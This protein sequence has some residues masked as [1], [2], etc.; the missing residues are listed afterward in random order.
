MTVKSVERA[1]TAFD[2]D[3]VQPDDFLKASEPN[4][5]LVWSVE[6]VFGEVAPGGYRGRSRAR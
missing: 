3:A 4:L 1:L 5:P 2:A 6:T